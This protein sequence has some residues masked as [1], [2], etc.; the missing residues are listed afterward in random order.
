[1]NERPAKLY[2]VAPDFEDNHPLV[3]LSA[4]ELG[5]RIAEG[6][7][8]SQE[9]VAHALAR[10]TRHNPTLQA[11]VHIAGARAM[12]A[13]EK[14]DRERDQGRLRGPLHGVPTSVKDHH[15][16]A[17]ARSRM[18]SHAFDWLY[19]PVDDTLVRRLGRAGM[20]VLGKTSMSELGILPTVEPPVHPPTRNPWNTGHTAGGS[21]G[22]AGSGIAAGFFPVAQ[23]SDGAGSIRIPSALCG[24]VGLKPTRGIVPDEAAAARVNIFGLAVDG[25][26]GRSIDDVA[27]MLDTMAGTPAARTLLAS[28]QSVGR[29]RIGVTLDAPFGQPDPRIMAL[30]EQAATQLQALGHTLVPRTTPQQGVEAFLPLYQRFVSRIPMPTAHRLGPF[31]RW[32]HDEG[33]RISTAEAWRLFR[34]FEH[35]GATLA[36]DIDVMLAPSVAVPT[37]RIGQWAHLPPREHFDA[38]AT[39]GM[40]TALANVTGQPAL[41][42]PRGLVDGLPAGIQLVGAHHH[43]ARLLA[44]ARQLEEAGE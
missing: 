42:L 36:A 34:H 6:T 32:F 20:V 9:L 19:S 30:V 8:R 21:S 12:K 3:R 24:L 16:M 35:L 2:P 39:L 5:A 15:N 43:D 37:P 18:G 22:G 31:A 26:M 7:L 44:L 41:H 10:I 14:A 25:P 23:G 27:T 40:F 29:L 33:R 4:L 13:A 11:M 1:M 28:R 38:A 17:F